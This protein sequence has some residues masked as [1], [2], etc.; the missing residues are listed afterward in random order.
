MKVV[1]DTV[2]SGLVL[3]DRWAKTDAIQDVALNNSVEQAT[4]AGQAGTPLT[5][6]WSFFD[7]NNS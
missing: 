7:W 6:L 2:C 3:V 5:Y 1:C 4:R